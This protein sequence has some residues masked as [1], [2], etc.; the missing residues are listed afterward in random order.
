MKKLSD[1]LYAVVIRYWPLLLLAG[2]VVALLMR[3]HWAFR[4]L[5]A[6]LVVLVFI[7][8]TIGLVVSVREWLSGGGEPAFL[9]KLRLRITQSRARLTELREEI[10]QIQEKMHQLGDISTRADEAG[11][12]KQW[13]KSL[14]LARGYEEQLKLRE[15]KVA[16]YRRSLQ[17][18]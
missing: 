9:R 12:G 8:V 6:A 17:S 16:F 1:W 4:V 18:F 3:V 2:A 13:G 10:Q 11:G 15:E 14:A 5:A 7:G